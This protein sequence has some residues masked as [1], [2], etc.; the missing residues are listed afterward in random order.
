[1]TM[2]QWPVSVASFRF[3]AVVPVVCDGFRDFPIAAGRGVVTRRPAEYS[4]RR[5]SLSLLR[6][7][8]LVGG[9][10]RDRRPGDFLSASCG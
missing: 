9:R 2:R 8:C 4:G 7:L 5:G 10:S 3:D 6:H 1:M